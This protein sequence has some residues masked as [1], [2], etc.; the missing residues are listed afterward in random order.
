MRNSVLKM[1][2]ENNLVTLYADKKKKKRN[3]KK[4]TLDPS[5]NNTYL[6]SREGWVPPEKLNFLNHSW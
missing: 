2:R 6:C 4:D 1:I 3:K 5:G